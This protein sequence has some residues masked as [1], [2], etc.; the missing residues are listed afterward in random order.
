MSAIPLSLML[1]RLVWRYKRE[2]RIMVVNLIL[3]LGVCHC[4]MQSCIEILI[5]MRIVVRP[6]L[7]DVFDQRERATAYIP[8]DSA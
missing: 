5:R 7:W 8:K 6:P 2:I 3:V 1:L 4:A